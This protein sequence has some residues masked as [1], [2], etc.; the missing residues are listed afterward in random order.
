MKQQL[1]EILE[2]YGESI[3][4][5]AK[6]LENILNDILIYDNK[7]DFFVVKIALQQGLVWELKNKGEE[8]ADIFRYKLVNDYGFTEEKANISLFIWYYALFGVEYNGIRTNNMQGFNFGKSEKR[9]KE[10]KTAEDYKDVGDKKYNLCT[11]FEIPIIDIEPN[12]HYVLNKDTL[13]NREDAIKDYTN[14]IE[15]DPNNSFAYYKRGTLKFTL[16][17]K[18]GAIRDYSRAIEIDPKYANAYNNRGVAKFALGDKEGAIKDYTK[19]IE[20][21][22]ICSLFYSNRGLVKYSLGENDGAELDFTKAIKLD[23][24]NQNAIGMLEI[25]NDNK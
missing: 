21:N 17:D 23:P 11:G 13:G 8:Y 1:K 9:D 7:S 22:P 20:I 24:N 15:I 25:I 14:A 19:A 3:I 10:N 18:E 2:E 6:K 5:E 4:K 16:G 12:Y